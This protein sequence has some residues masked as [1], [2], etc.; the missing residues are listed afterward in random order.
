MELIVLPALERYRPELIVVACGYDASVVDPLSRMMAHSETYRYLMQATLDAAA[1]LCNGR[2]VVMHEGGY[3]EAYV[4]FCGHALI[5]ALAGHRTAVTDPNI[6]Y[7]A[8]QQPNDD[9][10][11]LQRRLLEEQA[12]DL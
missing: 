9:F 12:K 5:E 7:A 8:K 6:D 11:K 10:Q 1:E 2:V 4:P 3:S